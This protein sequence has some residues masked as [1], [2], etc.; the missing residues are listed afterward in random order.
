MSEMRI[1]Q[2]ALPVRCEICH[3]SDLFDGVTGFCGRCVVVQDKVQRLNMQSA[4]IEGLILILISV[5][6]L[7]FIYDLTL[8]L[9]QVEADGRVWIGISL[10]GLLAAG[11]HWIRTMDTK[12]KFPTDQDRISNKNNLFLVL[13][14]L[15]VTMILAPLLFSMWVISGGKHGSEKR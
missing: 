9:N 8:G 7:C 1:N 14:V 13:I 2:E 3:Q 15:L 4:R 6:S 10:F 5:L 12:W 11:V